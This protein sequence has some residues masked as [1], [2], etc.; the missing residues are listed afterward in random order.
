M[1]ND[2]NEPSLKK[3]TRFLFG[4][5]RNISDPQLFHKISLI[6]FFAWVGLGVDGLTSSCY[7]P[8]EAFLTLGNHL[9]LSLF[10]GLGTVLTIFI[11]AT[12]YKQIIEL[13]P[14]GGGGYLVASKLISPTIGMVS[15]CAL[16]IDY[17]LTITLSIAS[18][19]DAIFSF[20]PAGLLSYKLVVACFGVIMLIWLNMRGVK[21][22]VLPLVPIFVL[23]ILTHV[24][25]ILYIIFAN[26]GNIPALFH[27]TSADIHSTSGS[28]GFLGM[29]FL[30]LRSYSMGAGTFT[31]IEAVSNGIPIL[32]EPRVQTAKK[33]MNYMAFS[34]S[35]MVAGLLIGYLILNVN[36]VEGKTLNAVLFE[37]MTAAWNAPLSY[38]FV[39]ACLVSEAVLL[40]LAAQTGFLDGPRVLSN[41]ALDKWAPTRFSSLS[42][43]LV[44]KNG[45]L[46]MGIG[47]IALMIYSRGDVGFLVILYS[48]N[49]FIT[50]S[51]SQLGMVRHWW[52]SRKSESGWLK[53]LLINGVGLTLTLFILVSVII[54]KFFEG[55]WITIVITGLLIAGSLFVKRHYNHTR[56]MLRRL[57]V[58]V[59]AA[60]N[61]QG[62]KKAAAGEAVAR[63]DDSEDIPCDA[64][65]KTAVLFVNGFT[66]LGLH[67]LF[68]I[69][70]LF[71]GVYKNFV[72]VQ[73]GQIDS[74]VFKGHSEMQ[75]LDNQCTEDAGK[76]IN[77]MNYNGFYAECFTSLAVDVIEESYR[78]APEIIKKFPNSVFFAGQ[79]V[80][81]EES[82]LTRWLHNYTAFSIQRKFYTGGIPIVI[83]PIRV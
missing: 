16:L 69:L 68:A 44:T 53:K 49:V 1:S 79:L 2:N 82:A 4:G 15:G 54:L 28:L 36:H 41:M 35:F 42:D 43:R 6:A 67:T 24:F 75:E 14:S 20:L 10:V 32:R 57:D 66:G 63:T 29:I 12:S 56:K 73:I 18:G 40:F 30:I 76:Y 25:A 60:M 61:E 50:F 48:I 83:L 34:L 23:F 65:A 58:L 17:L 46:I 78:I 39:L 33:T 51:L 55:G 45:I 27:N 37:K 31:G 5:S 80:F 47:S 21:E 70:R 3:F 22:S 19:A 52:K 72:F 74:G 77:Y 62:R 8:E 9:Y 11:I 38:V 71:S 64:K 59:Q 26:T 7:G 81:P 13:F